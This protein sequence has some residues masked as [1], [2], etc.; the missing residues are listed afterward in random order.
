MEYFWLTIAIASLVLV[1]Y[2][3]L[4]ADNFLDNIIWLLIPAIA[5]AY[6]GFRRAMRKRME[7]HDNS[8][9]N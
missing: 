8:D 9:Q 5:F 4:M 7:Q 2:D 1:G 3:L 6:Y